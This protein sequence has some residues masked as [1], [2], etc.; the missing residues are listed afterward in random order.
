MHAIKKYDEG[1]GVYDEK[2]VSK[3]LLLLL[4]LLL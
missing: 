1:E 4:L 3:L 2:E